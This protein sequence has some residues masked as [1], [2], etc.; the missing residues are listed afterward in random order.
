[1]S[2]TANPLGAIRNNLIASFFVRILLITLISLGLLLS[3]RGSAQAA[4]CNPGSGLGSVTNANVPMTASGTYKIWV[5]MKAADT[6]NNL[7]GVEAFQSTATPTCLTAGGAGLSS[8]TWTWKLAGEAVLGTSSN[9]FRLVGLQPNVKVDRFIA[10]INTNACTPSDTRNTAT[11]EEPGD[12]CVVVKP[13]QNIV[14]TVSITAP[15]ANSTLPAGTA[16]P[17]NVTAADS[18]GTIAKVEFYNGT[19]KLGEDLTAPYTVSLSQ[20]PGL[21]ANLKAIAYDN[22]GAQAQASVTVNI[23]QVAP[24]PPSTTPVGPA[25]INAALNWDWFRGSYYIWAAWPKATGTVTGYEIRRNNQVLGTTDAST[26]NFKDFAIAPN[27]P[28][29]YQVVALNGNLRSAGST[30]TNLTINCFWIFCGLR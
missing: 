24:P 12:N 13:V 2:D 27:I 23:G 20:L 6:T 18:D 29:S 9:T 16:S 30:V 1:M 10:V 7:V 15:T 25:Y 28:Y 3:L 22:L 4:N 19:T 11:G 5:R 21:T 14:P 8:S 26:L 17:F